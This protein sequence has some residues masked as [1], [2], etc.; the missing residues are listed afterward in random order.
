[1]QVLRYFE[2][3]VLSR[4][5]EAQRLTAHHTE[6][7]RAR[8]EIIHSTAHPTTAPN[9]TVYSHAARR[10]T[11]SP[12]C[13]ACIIYT[14]YNK[15]P[16]MEHSS[17][18]PRNPQTGATNNPWPKPA[19]S[20]PWKLLSGGPNQRGQPPAQPCGRTP[21]TVAPTQRTTTVVVYC[22]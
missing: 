8:C 14:T 16:Q 20:E 22:I 6:H 19:A 17:H 11:V 10:G 18:P 7:L 15:Q 12:T 1:M 3:N 4:R 2:T 5:S 13:T 21:S 9:S